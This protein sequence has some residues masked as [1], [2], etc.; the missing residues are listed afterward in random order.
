[1]RHLNRARD[2]A[3]AATRPK[4]LVAPNVVTTGE[5]DFRNRLAGGSTST[6]HPSSL[7]A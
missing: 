5:D 1:L 4:Q 3:S 2:K 7:I 6:V